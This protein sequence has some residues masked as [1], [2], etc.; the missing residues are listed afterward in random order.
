MERYFVASETEAVVPLPSFHGA[1]GFDGGVLL[2][3]DIDALGRRQVAPCRPRQ[4]D[5]P[6]FATKGYPARRS[7]ACLVTRHPPAPSRR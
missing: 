3:R 2:G 7:P 1:D 5:S 6:E 4:Y